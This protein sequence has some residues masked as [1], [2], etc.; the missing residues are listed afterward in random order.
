MNLFI[1]PTE[2]RM[3]NIFFEEKNS[4]NKCDFIR[5]FH[6]ICFYYIF[7]YVHMRAP[8]QSVIRGDVLLNAR[9]VY[10]MNDE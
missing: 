2:L 10:N 6:H 7:D 3:K 9:C 4:K 1:Y 5:C 8:S